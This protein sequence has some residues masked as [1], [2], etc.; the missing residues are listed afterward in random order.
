MSMS[1]RRKQKHTWQSVCTHFQYVLLRSLI[2]LRAPKSQQILSRCKTF[3]GQVN[4]FSLSLSRQNERSCGV[5][6]QRMEKTWSCY[7]TS[8][9]RKCEK[10]DWLQRRRVD[11]YVYMKIGGREANG[12]K[13][14]SFCFRSN[15]VLAEPMIVNVVISE[16]SSQIKSLDI[17]LEYS[18][19]SILRPPIQ[20]GF[21]CILAWEMF[22]LDLQ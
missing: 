5:Q 1:T 17:I 9:G 18:E 21:H 13:G 2:S 20:G 4:S 8:S 16:R 11:Y 19:I 12:K 7:Q 15:F 22:E 10:Q 6:K 3:D 14:M